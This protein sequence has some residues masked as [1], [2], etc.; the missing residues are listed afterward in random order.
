MIFYQYILDIIKTERV[1]PM[2][3]KYGYEGSEQYRPLSPWAYFWYSVLFL[4]PVIGFIALLVFTFSSTN[5]NRRNFARSYWCALLITVIIAL[6]IAG[7]NAAGILP[8]LNHQ[9]EYYRQVLGSSL[10]LY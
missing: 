3:S 7:L 10:N 4:I 8:G 5:I 6:V 1:K 2:Y 9:L